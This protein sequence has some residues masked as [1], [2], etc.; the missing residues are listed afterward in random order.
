MRIVVAFDVSMANS[1][2][3]SYDELGNCI[4]EDSVIHSRSGFAALNEKIKLLT[5]EYGTTPEFVF[6]ATGVY[7]R[8]LERFLQQNNYR[9][10]QLNPLEAKFQT[11]SLRRNKTDKSDAHELAKSHFK[12]ERNHTYQHDDYYDNM[13]VLSRRYD[14]IKKEESIYKNR[15]HALLQLSFPE[16][17]LIFE[18][19][20]VMF[21]NVIKIFPHPDIVLNLSKTIIRNQIKKC[22]KKNYSLKKLEERALQ[23]MDAANE[24]YPAIEASSYQC[25]LIINYAQRLLDLDQEQKELVDKMAKLSEDKKEYQV[26]LSF[27]GIK[28]TTACRIIAELGDIRRFKNNKQINAFVG[29]DTVRYQSGTIQHKDRINK[30]GNPR[31]RSILYFMI[32]SMLSAK[33]KGTNHLVDHYYKLKRQPQNKHHKVAIIACVNKF[34]KIAFHLIQHGILYDYEIASS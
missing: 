7:S 17:E 2:V 28:K 8:A 3:V 20:S 22:T 23:I 24:S 15:L 16:M 34:L 31:L 1:V 4:F 11:M 19:K 32:F 27:P 29:I 5:I 6:E 14:D 21:L 12:N 13:R 9:Y 10:C 33:G 26:L 25:D 30:R 18:D